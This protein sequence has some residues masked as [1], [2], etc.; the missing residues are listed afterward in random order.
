M[1]ALSRRSLFAGACAIVALGSS[2][3]PAAANPAVKKI[4]GGQAFGKSE[5]R[6]STFKSWWRNTYWNH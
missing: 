1:E 3:V 6:A 2:E 5:S 4:A